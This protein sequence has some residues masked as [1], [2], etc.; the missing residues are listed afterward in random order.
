MSQPT[1]IF[2]PALDLTGGDAL[3][4]DSGNLSVVDHIQP[5]SLVAGFVSV[6]TEHGVLLLDDDR[7]QT[8][9]VVPAGS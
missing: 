5:G 2:K 1:T 4:G 8:F 3:V 6:W 7:E 9:E